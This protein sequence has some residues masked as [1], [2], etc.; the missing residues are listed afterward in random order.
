MHCQNLRY[1]FEKLIIQVKLYISYKNE[2]V[3]T[4][5]N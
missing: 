1:D 4:H 5:E 3:F 2:Q